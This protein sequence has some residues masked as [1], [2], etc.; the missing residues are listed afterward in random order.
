MGGGLRRPAPLVDVRGDSNGKQA[1]RETAEERWKRERDQWLF[2]RVTR[3]P[4]ASKEPRGDQP[5]P[6]IPRAPSYDPSNGDRGREVHDLNQSDAA[7]GKSD[8]AFLM[9]E[10][11]QMNSHFDKIRDAARVRQYSER[12]FKF[13]AEPPESIRHGDIPWLPRLSPLSGGGY[14]GRSRMDSW[15]QRDDEQKEKFETLGVNEGDS[16]DA[17]KAALRAASLRWHPDKFMTK[18]GPKIAVEDRGKIANDVQATMQRIT[19][20]KER[21]LHEQADAA[22]TK[23]LLSPPGTVHMSPGSAMA[24]TPG[25]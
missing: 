10:R 16:I 6:S 18:Y 8:K 1:R 11:M 9:R 17:K 14:L 23:A 19:K 20:L 13:S 7:R 22:R 5:T 12:W 24:A 4:S 15:S 3:D 2:G 25:S 21:L